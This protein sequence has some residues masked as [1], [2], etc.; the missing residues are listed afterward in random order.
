MVG[1]KTKADQIRATGAEICVAPC[2]NCKKQVAEVCEDH[3]LDVRVC[4]L[5]DLILK[6]IDAPDFMKVERT[7]PP[8][9][10][11]R[12][13]RRRR[14]PDGH[15]DRPGPRARSSA[16]SL[17]ICLL[18]LA[19][20]LGI[21]AL[22][23]PPSHRRAGDKRAGPEGAVL[24]RDPAAGCCPGDADGCG[25]CYT[26]ASLAFH[27]GILLVPL[28]YVGHVT[29]WAA[30]PARPGGRTLGPAVSDVLTLARPGRA[31]GA[32]PARRLLVR[33]EPRPD[34]RRRRRGSCSCCSLVTASGYWAAHPAS[35]PLAPRADAAGPHAGRQ[36][37][38]D[39]HAP[40]QDRPLRP[41]AADP[42]AER[43]R[44]ALPGRERR[45]TWPSPWPRRTNRY[46]L[47]RDPDRR[48]QVHRLRGVRR[49]LQEDQRHRRRRRP[50]ASGRARRP[51]CRSTRWTTIARTEGRYVRV[52]CRHCLEPACAAACPVGALHTTDR[53][54]GGLRR[55]ASAWAAAT[56]WWPAPSA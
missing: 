15:L 16:I 24:A 45:A 53:G 54:R 19:Y 56:A 6:A 43:G 40:D 31:A 8:T 3:G 4:G 17:A 9:A 42:A 46:E 26:V 37:G 22:A 2:A 50:V 1:G 28:F 36:P 27:A 52:H 12:P 18:G 55:R 13:R 29:L 32:P 10:T 7:T 14:T 38:P 44:L 51:T 47:L 41:G 34:P 20:R 21:T 30:L 39:P 48:D 35:S 25:R 5:H 49:R 11:S 33:A 23:D